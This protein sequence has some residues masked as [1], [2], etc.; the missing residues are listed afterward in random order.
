MK[1][2]DETTIESHAPTPSVR[3]SPTFRNCR[4]TLRVVCAHSNAGQYAP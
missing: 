2:L 1:R 4:A 3:I